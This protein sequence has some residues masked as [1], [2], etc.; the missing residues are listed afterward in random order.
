MN[1]E[2]AVATT[3][4]RTPRPA[5]QKHRWFDQWLAPKGDC[6]LP[7]LA[8]V[9]RQVE[10]YER[11]E[12][13][14]KRKR[15]AADLENYQSAMRTTVANL[16]Y[17]VLMPPVPTGRLAVN[18]AHGV[19]GMTRYDN[20]ALGSKPYYK[21]LA[22]LFMLDLIDWQRP[23]VIRGE[24]TSVA[25]MPVFAERVRDTG[26][27]LADFARVPNEEVVVLTKKRVEKHEWWQ[28]KA[29]AKRDRINYKDKPETDA[30]RADMQGINAYLAAADIAFLDDGLE[31][32]VDP[33]ARVL[34]RMF[35]LLADDKRQRFDRSGR[36]FGGWWQPLKSARRK[37]IRING[38]PVAE[39]DYGSMFTRLAYAKLGRQAPEG[40][41]YAIPELAGH[42]AGVKLAMNTLLFDNRKTRRTWPKE[43]QDELPEGWG[44]SKLKKAVLKRHPL[45]E[46]VWGTAL[47]Y[48]LMFAESQVMVSVL[49]E[50]MSRGITALPIHD[51]LL[52]PASRKTTARG[53]MVEAARSI[54]DSYIPV[55]EKR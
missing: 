47:G 55:E 40:D 16:A 21:L 37:N 33:Y 27:T 18:I 54:T 3:T 12:K 34:R 14:R 11:D 29:E 1:S 42:R 20:R 49:K 39:L 46:D 15:K 35:V 50:L 41:L 17:A 48:E 38:E 30:L 31:P 2:M 8:D 9:T 45:L 6:W 13:T 10:Q 32:H 28:P 19:K 5:P 25:P 51:A 7:L 36:L 22:A 44:V 26:I 52:V 43:V 4:H 53:V 23:K 24:K